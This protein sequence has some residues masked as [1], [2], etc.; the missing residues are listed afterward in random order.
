MPQCWNFSHL[1]KHTIIMAYHTRTHAHT[2]ARTHTRTHARTHARTHVRTH[3]RTHTRTHTCTNTSTHAR[4]QAHMHEHKHTEYTTSMSSLVMLRAP[5]KKF[6]TIT[7]EPKKATRPLHSSS[8]LSN[9]WK[10][11]LLGW[12]MVMTI[13]RPV[14]ASACRL[15]RISR[16]DAES[17]PGGQVGVAVT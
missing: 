9:V 10:I 12:W 4:T 14:S 15:L 8:I 6:Q 2:H 1:H 7:G 3:A 5:T 16:D 17:R 11:S 13:A